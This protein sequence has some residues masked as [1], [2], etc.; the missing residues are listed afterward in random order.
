MISVVLTHTTF[1]LCGAVFVRLFTYRRQG[2]RFRRGMSCMAMLLMG[3]SGSAMLQIMLGDLRLPAQAWSL[4]LLLAVFAV[5]VFRSG[6]NLAG[7][8]RESHPQ[9]PPVHASQD[10]ERT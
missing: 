7:V 6:G 3:S 4:V 2:A 10:N 5:A 9:G 8:I 1:C